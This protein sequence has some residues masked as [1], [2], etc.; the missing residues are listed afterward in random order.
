MGGRSNSIRII[1]GEFRG[2]RLSFA[3]LPGLRPTADRLRETLFNWLQ[4][5]VE[6]AACLDL[7]AGSGALGLEALSRGADFVRLVDQSRV[8]VRQLQQ[9]L[10]TLQQ[11]PRGEVVAG[12]ALRLLSRDADR[13]FDLVFL[14]PPFARDW[15]E[16]ACDLLEQNHWLKPRSWIYLEQDSHKDWPR[17][18]PQWSLYREAGAGQAACRL[19]RR[20]IMQ[21]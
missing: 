16:N 6:G 7:F 17:T 9:N 13:S 5:Q 1:G 15:L 3:N 19:F 2:R 4:G 11:E 8:V 21:N 20:D 10:K 14:D 18:P 12:D